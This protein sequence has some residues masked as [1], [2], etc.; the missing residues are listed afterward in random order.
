MKEDV[1]RPCIV[2]GDER[3]VSQ[4]ETVYPEHGYPGPFVIR[5]CEGCGLLFNSPRLSGHD[6]GKLYD[7]NYYFFLRE[8][9]EEF[10]RIIRMCHRIVSPVQDRV[11]GRRVVEIGSAKGY[12]LALL[13]AL[14]WTVQGVELSADAARFALESL[15][16]P[17]FAGTVSEFAAGNDDA[18]FPLALALDVLEHVPDPRQFLEDTGRLLGA[19]GVLVIDTPNADAE[20]IVNC[21]AAWRGFN[22][23]HIFFFSKASIT[24]LLDE[25][26]YDVEQVHTYGL[27]G[28][29]R[30]ASTRAAI[31]SLCIA[32]RMPGA[33]RLLNRCRIAV[34]RAVRSVARGP[35]LAVCL[36][37]AVERVKNDV[38]AGVDE[39][40]VDLLLDGHH[41]DNMVVV[42]RKR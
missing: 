37:D 1:N 41:G 26:G 39:Q 28:K 19:G 18:D 42:A 36:A 33:A 8:D 12:L 2:C 9:R 10:E 27:C 23:F 13:K 16:V 7:D 34:Q 5:R 30:F 31:G 22:P 25:C 20:G 21:G 6:L 38:A 11:A 14:G 3:S 32:L 17:C 29:S 35:S 4:L 40:R 15:D 24:R